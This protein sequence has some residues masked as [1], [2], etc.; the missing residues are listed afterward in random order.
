MKIRHLTTIA[1]LASVATPH[2]ALINVNFHNGTPQTESVLDGPGGGANSTWNQ[3]TEATGTALLDSSGLVTTTGFTLPHNLE[4]NDTGGWANPERVMQIGSFG[5]FGKGANSTLT[6]TGLTVGGLYDV[7]I[8]STRLRTTSG[9]ESHGI[10]ST[11]N[12]TS[13]SSQ[14]VDGITSINGDAWVLGTNYAFFDNV[15]ADTNGAI[16]FLGD[17]TDADELFAG[18]T[19]RRLHINGFQIQAVPEPS[20]ALLGCLGLLALL[21]RRR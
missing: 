10:F 7:W 19:A 4:E 3:S 6:I 17:A 9:E 14:L 2:A 18:S 20:T 11:T 21:R 15:V 12:T 16:T 5:Q 1:I 8:A 13:S